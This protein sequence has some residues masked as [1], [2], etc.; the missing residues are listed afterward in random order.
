MPRNRNTCQECG[1][2]IAR[3]EQPLTYEGRTICGNCYDQIENYENEDEDDGNYTESYGINSYS[4]KPDNIFYST[5]SH[6]TR[7]SSVTK[8]EP[9]FGIEL[10]TENHTSRERSFGETANEAGHLTDGFVYSKEDCSLRNGFEIVSHPATLSYWQNETSG[11]VKML[12]MLRNEGYRAW[13]TSRCGLHI[14]ISKDSFVKPAHDMKF[15]Y[16]IFRNKKPIINLVARN[17]PF[18]QFNLDSFLGLPTD[19]DEFEGWSRTYKKPTL[20]EVAKGTCDDGSPISRQSE[21]N[22]A[23][24]RLPLDTY[25]LRIFRPSLRFATILAYIEFLHCL[26]EYTKQITANDILQKQAISTF[27]PL[28]VYARENKEKYPNFIWKMHT[29][30]EVSKAPQ[31]WVDNPHPYKTGEQ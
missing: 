14:H 26:F 28:A 8:K 22:L 19:E 4:H 16:F 25:E 5:T 31:N 1:S 2:D 13:T 7:H 18:A 6:P 17:S 30:P 24:N 29:R 21:R 9:F 12:A 20:I 23:V 27:E 15:I 3:D 11:Y 10:E